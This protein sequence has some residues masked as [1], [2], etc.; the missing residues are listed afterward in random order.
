MKDSD[1]TFCNR[2]E[3]FQQLARSIRQTKSGERIAITT[4]AFD[5]REPLVASLMDELTAAADRGVHAYLVIDAFSFLI[6]EKPLRLGP[7]WFGTP[8]SQTQKEPFASRY[9]SLET[10]RSHG[11]IYAITNQPKTRF[12]LPQ[13]GR[14]HIKTAII[15]NTIYIGGHNLSASEE[16]DIMTQWH[17]SKTANYLYNLICT[18]AKTGSVYD[19]LKG[20][21]TTLQIDKVNTLFFDAGTPKSSLILRRALQLIDEAQEWIYITCQ[22]FPGGKTAQH[23]LAAHKRGVHVQ[24]LY[25]NPHAHGKESVGHYVY[26]LR[27]R[28]RLPKSFF[29][30]QLPK[31]GPKLHAKLIA[32]EK[33]AMLGSHN[34]V[35]QGVRLGT[36]EIALLRKDPVFSQQAVLA[37][38]KALRNAR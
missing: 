16:V 6:N 3:Y 38:T 20:R 8:L 33:G 35:S 7:L 21:D 1:F 9:A 15:G 13:A 22:Y 37:I 26:N 29:E 18:T 32:T 27:E 30:H 17:D 34:Y 24:I 36:A 23:L 10:F 5:S 31:H 4:M 19:T 2:V 11:G 14:S 28:L 12:T 25:S